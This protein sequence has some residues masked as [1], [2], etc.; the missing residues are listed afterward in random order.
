MSPEQICQIAGELV[1]LGLIQLVLP[2]QVTINA[3][4]PLRHSHVPQGTPGIPPYN[5]QV[6]PMA[7]G[8]RA[9]HDESPLYGSAPTSTPLPPATRMLAPS[10]TPLAAP[11]GLETESQWGNGGNGA[12]FITGRGWVVKPQP[13]RPLSASGPIAATPSV[14]TQPPYAYPTGMKSGAF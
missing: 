11:S 8:P 13:L 1:L 4:S 7:S 5:G 2:G 12:T 9:G 10:A 6:G 3:M 14:Q